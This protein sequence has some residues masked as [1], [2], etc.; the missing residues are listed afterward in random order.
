MTD[1]AHPVLRS[2]R[3]SVITAQEIADD[4]RLS[5]AKVFRMLRAG[6]INGAYKFGNIWRV[7]EEDYVEWRKA[8]FNQQDGAA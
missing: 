3:A 1:S 5:K 7:L 8:K 6:E 2:V 4:L